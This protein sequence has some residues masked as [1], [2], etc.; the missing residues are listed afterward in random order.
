MLGKL[1]KGGKPT[2]IF[3][4]ALPI[5]LALTLLP[6]LQSYIALGGESFVLVLDFNGPITYPL[7]SYMAEAVK[8]AEASNPKAIIILLNTLGGSLDVTLNIVEAIEASPIPIIAFVYPRGAKAWSAGTI[9]LLASHIAAMAPNTLIGSCQPVECTPYGGCRPVND[10]KVINAISSLAAEKARMHGRNEAVA[11]RFVE[12]NLNINAEQAK[13]LRVVEVVAPDLQDLLRS[14]DGLTVETS[15]GAV[16]LS[17]HEA[18]IIKFP[19][20]LRVSLLKTFSDPLIASLLLT[21]GIWALIIGLG[22]PG[23]GAEIAG[24][25]AIILG[26]VGL[27]FNINLAALLLTLLGAAFLIIEIREPGFGV[28][29]V[30]GLLCVTLG[31]LFLIPFHPSR[32]IISQEWYSSFIATITAISVTFGGFISIMLFKTIKAARLKPRIAGIIGEVAEAL[33]DISKGKQGFI[34]CKGEYWK[35]ASEYNVKKGQ[36]VLIIGKEGSIL[37]I[38]PLEA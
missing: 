3:L 35:A 25:I 18:S 4:K 17:T 33:E 31:L 34:L 10:P 32:W 28:F 37:I 6:P 7:Q 8:D 5:L 15:R 12:E 11:R 22:T 26:L 24:A 27:G 29:G 9:I 2:K 1:L 19:P 30:S 14:V 20:S 38:K 36:K 21:I 16:K 13:D 23:Y